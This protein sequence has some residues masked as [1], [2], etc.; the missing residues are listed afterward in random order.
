MPNKNQRLLIITPSFAGGGAEKVAINLA[1]EY[2]AN[3]IHVT[4]LVI[5]N[6]G[7]YR[8]LLNSD[9]DVIDLNAKGYIGSFIKVF[10]ALKK[11]KPTKVLSVIRDVNIFVG[12]SYFLLRKP[13]LIYRE[14]NT[15]NHIYNSVWFKRVIW[16]L[17][18][19]S[20]YSNANYVIANSLG[21]KKHL[22]DSKIIKSSKIK[23]I[24]NPVIPKNINELLN[25]SV[26]DDWLNDP[27]LK[28]VLNVGRLHTQK[29]Q[30]LL[31]TS[32]AKIH[33]KI[34]NI[35]LIILGDGVEKERLINLAKNLGVADKVKIVPFQKNPY[36][37][38]KNASLFVL[39]SDYEGFGN[40]LVEALASGNPVISTMCPGG[41]ESILSNGSYG[42]LVSPGDVEELSKAMLNVLYG[43]IVYNRD[44][45]IS[46]SKEY[47]ISNIAKKYGRLLEIVYE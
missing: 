12:M 13:R 20:T 28:V 22:L 7:S 17:L 1:N 5:Q 40:V 27:E 45:L 41:P 2:S 36:P 23:V 46:R 30:S 38:Y 32:F 39:T 44:S 26:N 9:V 11:L 8:C 33:K 21:T 34:D 29:N 10:L 43:H 42:V 3:G 15:L 25:S 4:L 31:I 6:H 16:F 18:L 35:R 47:S 19:R 14:A 37:Y 24:D